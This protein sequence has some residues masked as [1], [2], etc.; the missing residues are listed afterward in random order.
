MEDN[1]NDPLF[2]ADMNLPPPDLKEIQDAMSFCANSLI[3]YFIS[4]INGEWVIEKNGEY[5]GSFILGKDIGMGS[6]SS[7]KDIAD[8]MM[9]GYVIKVFGQGFKDENTD[10][11][12][13]DQLSMHVAEA[14][15]C[16]LFGTRKV[17]VSVHPE[18]PLARMELPSGEHAPVL[19]MTKY[20][21]VL[22]SYIMSYKE[23]PERY[24]NTIDR[25]NLIIERLYYMYSTLLQAGF[26]CRD[27]RTINILVRMDSDGMLTDIRFGDMDL[28]MCCTLYGSTA[29]K[30][31]THYYL[32]AIDNGTSEKHFYPGNN[33][34]SEPGTIQMATNVQSLFNDKVT[35]CKLNNEALDMM[36]TLQVAFTLIAMGLYSK[37]RQSYVLQ[38]FD[39]IFS[40]R[41]S[42]MDSTIRD[43][44]EFDFLRL[45]MDVLNDI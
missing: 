43:I 9:K 39:D 21:T 41:E 5:V 36:L 11:Y 13:T 32:K 22:T 33:F 18:I 1:S 26:I 34:S 20:S 29:A 40:R 27:R 8:G 28:G 35:K 44:L 45:K 2:L 19:F 37:R 25:Q 6:Y 38:Y 42:D 30:A 17:S 7:V 16:K 23:H 24:A 14:G 31:L 3:S 15:A 4:N 10:V 12:E